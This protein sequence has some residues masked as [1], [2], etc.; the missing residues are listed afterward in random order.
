M[1]VTDDQRAHAASSPSAAVPADTASYDQVSGNGE[2][3]SDEPSRRRRKRVPRMVWW[4]VAL[5]VTVLGAYSIMLPTY[6]APDEPLHVD[7]AHHWS[8]DF[9]YPAWDSRDTSDG[10]INSLFLVR[11]PG[12]SAHLTADEATP[13]DE[14]PS[15]EDLDETPSVGGVN[16][17]PQHPP[18]YYAIAGTAE[19]ATE[20]VIGDPDFQ[21]ETWF[22]RL[23][24]IAMVAPLPFVIW[25]AS[26]LIGFPD[27]VAAAAMLLPLAI[28]Q[29]LHIGA[30]VNN[31]NLQFLTT[32]LMT[33]IV[34]RVARGDL[35]RRTMVGAGV[36]TGIGLFAKAFTF[37]IPAWMGCAL[38]LILLRLGRAALPRVVRAG[39]VY[40]VPT[41]LLGGWWWVRNV[42]LYGSLMPTRY[43]DLVDPVPRGELDLV[44][45]LHTW[46][47]GTIRRFWGDFGYFDTRISSTAVTIATTVAIVAL[48]VA[49]IGRDRIAGT[50][51]GDRLLL[52]APLVLLM[53]MQLQ[54]ALGTY[55]DIGQYAALQGRY[56][57]GALAALA[58]LLALGIAKLLGSFQR[59]LPVGVLAAVAVMQ[60]LAVSA[61]FGFY[62]GAPGAA[63]PARL[64]A[65][66]AW[67]PVPG[68]V[69][70]LAAGIG[71]IVWAAAVFEV[72]RLVVR[73]RAD[74]TA[75]RPLGPTAASV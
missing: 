17:L 45:Y 5:H 35:T 62:W 26:R 49:L 28:P 48:V 44:D 29:Y 24:S 3:A 50:K 15:Y 21:L 63:F 30:S 37:V 1:P 58:V 32:W 14:R 34:L 42:V 40:S 72:W 9:D 46:I 11:F 19:R 23:V 7:L 39:L 71:A 54:T 57:F 60:G 8:T 55:L 56:W 6:R 70:A 51:F 20:I 2:T 69:I 27:P 67:A 25:K 36:V 13:K 16:Q 52:L 38:V 4:I 31:D 59:W 10:V 33:P 53:A 65:M 18:L 22:Y 41:M 74:A 75:A 61:I 73:S 68:E 47:T 12:R 64:R 66:V 43:F